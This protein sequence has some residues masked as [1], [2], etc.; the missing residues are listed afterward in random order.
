MNNTHH[1]DAMCTSSVL[2]SAITVPCSSSSS[3][4]HSLLPQAQAAVNKPAAGSVNSTTATV[5]SGESA[6]VNSTALI[7]GEAYIMLLAITC[8]CTTDA[9]HTVLYLLLVSR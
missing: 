9:M 4:L 3:G 6:A 5:V 8:I 1:R 7:S 2:V